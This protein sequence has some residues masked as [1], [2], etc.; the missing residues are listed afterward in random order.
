[1]PGKRRTAFKTILSYIR[2]RSMYQHALDDRGWLPKIA[3]G[4]QKLLEQ[5][6]VCLR[7]GAIR[8]D[9]RLRSTR[10]LT[11]RWYELPDGYPG[12][13]TQDEALKILFADNQARA[14]DEWVMETAQ[15]D[16]AIS[17]GA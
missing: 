12:K 5:Q 10:K 2:C 13:M 17:A 8:V 7:C 11:S 15:A 16:A 4:G 1:M 6:L 9:Q 14:Y 3:P